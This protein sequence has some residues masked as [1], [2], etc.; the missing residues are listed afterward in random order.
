MTLH[1]AAW[2][3]MVAAF[4]AVATLLAMVVVSGVASHQS[5]WA[6]DAERASGT[7]YQYVTGATL[8]QR[9]SND[10]NWQEVSSTDKLDPNNKNLQ[11]QFNLAFELPIGAL[12]TNNPTLTYQVPNDIQISGFKD[13]E[14]VMSGTID[15]NGTDM[16][17]YTITK[18]GL[19]TLTFNE[20]TVKHNQT[21]AITGGY[22]KFN[23]TIEGITKGD[24][25]SWKFGE[26]SEITIHSTTQAI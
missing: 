16:G 19:I 23:S 1:S 8:K 26:N 4:V 14:T 6:D 15:N 7:L 9:S 3:R 12:T 2:R 11:L 21:G 25:S 24:G 20:D 10:E 13:G 18:D 17:T 22:V 5:A